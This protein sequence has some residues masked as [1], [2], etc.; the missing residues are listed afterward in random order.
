MAITKH[1]KASGHG[2]TGTIESWEFGSLAGGM[3]KW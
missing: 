2:A 3:A 1:Q